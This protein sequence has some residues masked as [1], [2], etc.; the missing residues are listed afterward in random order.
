MPS[1]TPDITPAQIGAAATAL[2]GLVVALGVPLSHDKQLAVT[3]FITVFAPVLLAADA[4]IRHGRANV[5]AARVTAEI[6]QAI[7]A[8][9]EWDQP[10]EPQGEP[11]EGGSQPAPEGEPEQPEEP[12]G[13]PEEPS[14]A[15]PARPPR[16]WPAGAQVGS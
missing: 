12:Q 10:S 2:I 3:T 13:E 9:A 7:P 5:A 8:R 16:R 11:D 15:T 1:K 6:A 14:G 4:A